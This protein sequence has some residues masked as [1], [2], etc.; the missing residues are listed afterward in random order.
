MSRED[1][2]A[3]AVVV[4]LWLIGCVCGALLPGGWFDCDAEGRSDGTGY[5]IPSGRSRRGVT[6]VDAGKLLV[7]RGP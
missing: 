2:T 4:V 1:I 7:G 3:A 6:R 5:A